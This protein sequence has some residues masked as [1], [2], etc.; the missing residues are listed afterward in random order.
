M[1]GTIDTR[2]KTCGWCGKRLG[3]NYYRDLTR[4]RGYFCS[5]DHCM[6]FI[7][8]DNQSLIPGLKEDE[9]ESLHEVQQKGNTD[10]EERDANN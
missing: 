2:A 1:P 6:K 5:G 3:D 9:T 4:A 8:N 7:E 10:Y